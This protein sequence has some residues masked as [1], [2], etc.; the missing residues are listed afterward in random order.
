MA[1]KTSAD[2]AATARSNMEAARV[3]V[4]ECEKKIQ[5]IKEA[6]RGISIAT[7]TEGGVEA[8]ANENS[9]DTNI[10]KISALKVRL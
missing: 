9:T 5:T 3:E 6:L 2:S 7:P 8:G 10:L 4:M 1:S